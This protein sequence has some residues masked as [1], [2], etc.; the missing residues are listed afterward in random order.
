MNSKYITSYTIFRATYLH[1]TNWHNFIFPTLSLTCICIFLPVCVICEL[2]KPLPYSPQLLWTLQVAY[3]NA[4]TMHSTVC[5]IN[6]SLHKN[7][8]ADR[9]YYTIYPCIAKCW[10]I[11]SPHIHRCAINRD[12][13]SP[14]NVFLYVIRV[15]ASCNVRLAGLLFDAILFA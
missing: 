14:G 11:H 9:A 3:F 15:S 4:Q 6:T 7:P 1:P 8:N 2:R 12:C 10:T 5:A 13:E